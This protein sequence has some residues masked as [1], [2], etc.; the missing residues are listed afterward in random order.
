MD[1]CVPFDPLDKESLAVSIE[2]ALLAEEPHALGE[3]NKF[4]GAGIYALCYT[5]SYPA[6]KLLSEINNG[7]L[8]VSVYVGKADS[9]ADN[10]M[11]AEQIAREV[12]EYVAARYDV[13]EF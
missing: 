4:A 11:S 1:E 7:F 5:G 8:A 9:L 3:I 12:E 6:Y 10:P 13:V 2:R